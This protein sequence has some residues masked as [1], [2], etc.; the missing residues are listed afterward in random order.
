M[1]SFKYDSPPNVLPFR[2]LLVHVDIV[3][4]A[5]AAL[6]EVEGLEVETDEVPSGGREVPDTLRPRG[7][8]IGKSRRGYPPTH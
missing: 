7:I 8:I 3:L 5:V 1:I 2:P 6:A 4:I